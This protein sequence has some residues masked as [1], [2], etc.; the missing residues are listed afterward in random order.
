MTTKQLMQVWCMGIIGCFGQV[1]IY[2]AAGSNRDA[3]LACI[4]ILLCLS[5]LKDKEGND[6]FALIRKRIKGY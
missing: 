2:K 4:V 6:I 3:F 1:S 5:L